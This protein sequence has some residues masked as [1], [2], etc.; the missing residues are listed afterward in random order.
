M[1]ELALVRNFVVAEPEK[2]GVRLPQRLADGALAGGFYTFADWLRMD[3]V[4]EQR[5]TPRIRDE[6]V[7]AAY[8]SLLR[9]MKRRVQNRMTEVL[10][11]TGKKTG[12]GLP[13]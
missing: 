11:G 4:D 8:M 7:R 12:S 1:S 5:G 13:K 10:R 3:E 9:M 2:L 6:G